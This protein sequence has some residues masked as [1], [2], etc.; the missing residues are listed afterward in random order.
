M[1]RVPLLMPIML[2]TSCTSPRA[3]PAPLPEPNAGASAELM[4]IQERNREGAIQTRRFSHAD[5]WG[6]LR[7]LVESSPTLSMHEIGRSAEGRALYAVRYG[8]GPTRVLLWSQM[9]GD[10]STATMALADLFRFFAREPDHP[11]ARRIAT[12]LSIEA[13]PM[14]NPD[15]AERFQRRNVYGIDVNRDARE[16]STPEARALKSAQERFRPAFGFNLHDQ[17]T[18]TTVGG[19]TRTAAIALL[20]PPFDASRSNNPVRDRARRVAAVVRLAVEPL[21]GEHIAKY[22]DTFNPRAFGD[23]MQQWGVSTVLIES[24]GLPQD[25]EKQHLRA[26]TFVA[27]LGALDAIATGA[28]A[29]ADPLAYESLPRNG[30]PINDLLLLG[31]RVVFGDL[32][33]VRA[34]VSVN[35]GDPLARTDGEIMEVGDLSGV[36]ARDTLD[37]SGLFLHPAAGALSRSGSGPALVPG[38]PADFTVRTGADALSSAVWVLSEGVVREVR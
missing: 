38:A 34:D 11:I 30:P 33:P 29:G 6:A 5:L 21:V 16:L 2:L 35:Y 22:S 17:N 20:A 4:A 3:A 28:Y 8:E 14:L 18:R 23:L 37:I 27:I 36:A 7:P 31:G 25:P 10:E 9:H 13:I 26:V 32:D 19:S 12:A 24:G 15:G 1:T